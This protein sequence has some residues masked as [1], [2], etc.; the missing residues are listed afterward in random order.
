LVGGI[1]EFYQVRAKLE[2][3]THG[4]LL[5]QDSPT[6]ANRLNVTFA[7]IL[8][9]DVPAFVL[10][11]PRTYTLSLELGAGEFILEL[12]GYQGPRLVVQNNDFHFNLLAS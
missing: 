6:Q 10:A 1:H 9:G 5:A 3:D 4:L 8:A 2:A 12:L 11:F 7:D